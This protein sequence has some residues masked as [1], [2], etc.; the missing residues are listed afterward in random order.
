MYKKYFI[1]FFIIFIVF[2]GCVSTNKIV[3]NNSINK[4]YN[5]AKKKMY[6]NDF[7]VAINDFE[8]LNNR[9]P[10]NPYYNQIQLNLIYCYYKTFELQMAIDVIDRFIHLNQ[11]HPNIDYVIYMRALI[12]MDLDD[13]V[14]Y[15]IFN[16]KKNYE[17]DTKNAY[18]AFKY[19]NQL[20]Y[21]FPESLYTNDAIKR[22][23]YLKNRLA[24]F[25]L[26][27][28][29]FYNKLG[30]YIAVI[31]RSQQMLQDYPSTKAT[32]EALK[33]MKIAYEKIGLIE[34]SKKVS[35]IILNNSKNF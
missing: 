8:F 17:R 35:D 30:V 27:V 33:Y 26:S 16:I 24:N 22:L 1:I 12:A 2:S 21:S 5:T 7:K 13:E 19:F 32:I 11:T 10:L 6:H 18:L 15:D 23:F 28:I 3:Y 14:L 25:D 4:I 34:E 20:I 31:N 29:K 9:Y